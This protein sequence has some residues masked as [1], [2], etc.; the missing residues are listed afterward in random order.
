M[1]GRLARILAV[2]V[3][4]ALLPATAGDA[5]PRR[6]DGPQGAATVVR[7]R[8]VD[9]RFRRGTITVDRGT[10]V[11]WMN[12]GSNIHTTT[13]DTGSWDSEE[14]APGEIF[15]KKFRRVGTFPYHCEIHNSM[16]GT[17]TVT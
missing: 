7:I 8:I 17:I 16:V 15:R 9:N 1:Q 11:K 3:L 4:V 12:T 6:H 10:V 13:S 14:L 5:A 2:A